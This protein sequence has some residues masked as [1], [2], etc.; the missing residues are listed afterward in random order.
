MLRRPLLPLLAFLSAVGAGPCAPAA[1]VPLVSRPAVTARGGMLTPT[2]GPHGPKSALRFA[3]AA[4]AARPQRLALA[5]P[6]PLPQPQ[7]ARGPATVLRHIVVIYSENVAFDHYF[8]TYPKA[9]NP[10]GEPAFAALPHTPR[11][12][13]LTRALLTANPTSANSANRDQAVNPFRLDRSQ[14]ATADQSHAYRAEQLAFDHGRMDLFPKYTSAKSLPPGPAAPPQPKGLAMGY[15][16]GN[17]VTA[18]WNYAQ[19]YALEDRSFGTTF[20]PSTVGAINL[21]SGQTNGVSRTVNGRNGIVPGG[22][23]SLTDI[24]DSDPLGDRCSGPSHTQFTLGGNNIG[25][26]LNAAHISWGWFQGGF[27]LEAVNPDGSTG[28]LRGHKSLVTGVTLTDYLPYHEP[29]QYYPST[30]NPTHRRPTSLAMIG[31]P[32]DAANHQYDLGD[33]FAAV[34]AGNFPAVSF[35]KAPAF[36][37]GHAGYSDPL[38]EQRYLVQVVNF[39]EQRPEWT[40]TAVIL[41]YDDSD[42]WYDHVASPQVNG[43]SGPEDAYTSPGVCGSGSPKLAGIAANNPRAQGRCGYGPRVPLLVISPWAR[44]NF[45]G[46]EVTD[47]TSILRLIEDTFLKGKRL[48]HG[49]YDALSG[50][51]DPLFDFSHP[52]PQNTRLLLLDESTGEIAKH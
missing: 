50:S 30:A 23:G 5:A 38:D 8:G 24:S 51:L 33:F 48:G 21:I 35:L 52:Q 34:R 6:R 42:G 37:D 19:H 32:G 20:G 14:A 17:T 26:L 7:P 44:P 41:A 3:G 47:Q 27:N 22:A 11:V 29:F 2:W 1:R 25:D 49:S 40:Q 9:L 46:S 4:P 10:P 31:K 28:C 12:D 39:L 43:S 15:F 36:E 18:V 45:V 16:D 13:G